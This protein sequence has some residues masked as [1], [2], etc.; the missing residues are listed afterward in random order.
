MEEIYSKLNRTTLTVAKN[1]V[2][3]DSR[4]QDVDA[5]LSSGSNELRVVGIHG[6]GGIGKTTIAKEIYNM[7]ADRF[8]GSSFLANIGATSKKHGV[9]RLQETLLSD[10]LGDMGVMVGYAYNGIELI[11]KNPRNK[12]IFMV[13]DDVDNSDKLKQLMGEKD[14]FG[15]GSRILI[16]TRDE[17]LLI[18]HG[19]DSRYKVEELQHNHA[20][21]LFSWNAFQKPRPRDQYI[22]HS[23]M[24]VSVVH[25][26]PLALI[27][28]GSYLYSKSMVHWTDVLQ[29]FNSMSENDV[30]A[31]IR[32]SF[33]ES[34]SNEES[35]FLDIACFFEGED[36][37]FITKHL[38][39]C[40]FHPDVGIQVLR[41]RA[42]IDIEHGKIYM[43]E[44]IQEFGKEVVRQECPQ[45]PGKRSR[46]WDHDD[47]RKVL[48]GNL[49]SIS[50][51]SHW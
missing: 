36:I 15:S 29:R 11:K 21:E 50:C 4:V 38:V 51:I 13:L 16:T 41:D 35:I 28:L 2:G 7:V 6:V 18:N 8:E 3:L 32:M 19:V 42:L 39:R 20:I 33:D 40:N 24:L 1:S 37:E 30:S 49:V 26:L 25:G 46:L 43:H 47:V 5:L 34:G 45:E 44:I 23:N 48:D 9:F 14:W 27:V 22:M 12:M 10:I 31:I 17:T